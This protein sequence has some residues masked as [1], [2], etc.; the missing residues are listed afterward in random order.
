[1]C[2]AESFSPS[3]LPLLLP[4]LTLEKV[5]RHSQRFRV[6]CYNNEAWVGLVKPNPY[7]EYVRSLEFVK[8]LAHVHSIKPLIDR[9]KI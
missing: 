5:T 1:M 3:V 7:M 2:V 4:R 9:F 6:N 8:L